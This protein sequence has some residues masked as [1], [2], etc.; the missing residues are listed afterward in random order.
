MILTKRKNPDNISGSTP[1]VSTVYNSN[2]TS[3][4]KSANRE[5]RPQEKYLSRNQINVCHLLI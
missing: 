4:A 1:E 3:E 5:S 2:I